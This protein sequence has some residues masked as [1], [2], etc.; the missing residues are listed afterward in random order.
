MGKKGA[1]EKQINICG[2]ELAYIHKCGL[3]FLFPRYL[4]GIENGQIQLQMA[5]KMKMCWNDDWMD[6]SIPICFMPAAQWASRLLQGAISQMRVTNMKIPTSLSRLFPS[7]RLVESEICSVQ[8]SSSAENELLIKTCAFCLA[9][10][11]CNI[12]DSKIDVAGPSFF[13]LSKRINGTIWK[14]LPVFNW[15]KSKS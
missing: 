14:I 5:T 12:Y 2:P 6:G 13:F 10:K 3:F 15:P 8:V 4:L 9:G 7:N 1:F 11:M